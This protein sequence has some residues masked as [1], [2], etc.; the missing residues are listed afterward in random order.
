MPLLELVP[1]SA[2]ALALVVTVLAAAL[3]V[4]DGVLAAL[5]L[6][7]FAVAIVIIARLV[8]S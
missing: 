7:G 8:T 5:G 6:G 1:F 3:L 2:T 4:R